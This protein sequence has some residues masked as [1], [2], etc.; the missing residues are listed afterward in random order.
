MA[1]CMDGEIGDARGEIG[2][3]GGVG[4]GSAA[5]E[6]LPNVLT[7]FIF[8]ISLCDDIWIQLN[9]FLIAKVENRLLG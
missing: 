8:I 5:A 9:R 1:T 2:D 4:R 7:L 3:A 6:P